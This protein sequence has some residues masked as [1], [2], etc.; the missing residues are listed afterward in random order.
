MLNYKNR[1]A[2]KYKLLYKIKFTIFIYAIKEFINKVLVF[3]TKYVK[4]SGIIYLILL[5]F[6]KINLYYFIFSYFNNTFYS[7]YSI[8][9][10]KL[11]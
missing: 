8:F 7:L 9:F 6:Y 3:K 2:K 11:F 5:L 10:N 4:L 1:I